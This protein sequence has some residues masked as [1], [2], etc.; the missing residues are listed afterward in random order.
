MLKPALIERYNQLFDQAEAAVR[1]CPTELERVK[2]SRLSLLYSEL[3]IMRT[4]A[5]T[6]KDSLASNPKIGNQSIDAI[7]YCQLYRERYL[8]KESN[9]AQNAQIIYL[10]QPSGKYAKADKTTLTDGILRGLNY[11]DDW[12]GWE[13]KNGSLI[14]DLGEIKPVKKN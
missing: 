11:V 4:I 10:E 3:E 12:I 5:D 8:I 9:L 13:G 6:D 1:N 2:R 14:I 7:R